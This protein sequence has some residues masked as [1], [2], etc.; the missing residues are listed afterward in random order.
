MSEVYL[1]LEYED[2][3]VHIPFRNIEYA[4]TF[5][6]MYEDKLALCDA[7]NRYLEL[8]YQKEQML[9]AY[10]SDDIRKIDDDMQEFEEPYLAVKYTRDL[11]D[12]NDLAIKLGELVLNKRDKVY[13]FS[14]LDKVINYYYKKKQRSNLAPSDKD[15]ANI[16]EA[17]LGKG[18]KRNKECYYKLKGLGYKVKIEKYKPDPRKTSIAL[19]EER[20]EIMCLMAEMKLDKLKA[21]VK[22]EE[23][24]GIKR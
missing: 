2:R 19:D 4:D 12:Y 15:G 22:E 7:V 5:T 24:K 16:A 20:K 6:C 17:Y 13:M 8:G 23:T 3:L 18:Y 11:Y 10:L 21:Y 1:V 9:D 14:G